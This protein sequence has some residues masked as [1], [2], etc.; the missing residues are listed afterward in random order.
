[1]K[2]HDAFLSD[3]RVAVFT[4]GAARIPFIYFCNFSNF[5]CF[6]WCSASSVCFCF[7]FSFERCTR[8]I[9][10][11]KKRAK[12]QTV[13]TFS[14]KSAKNRKKKEKRNLPHRRSAPRRPRTSS[15]SRPAWA[16]DPSTR[17][18][19]LV[20]GARRGWPGRTSRPRCRSSPARWRRTGRWS[21]TPGTMEWSVCKF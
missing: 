10:R 12:H 16:A 4:F 20:D 21:R 13:T 18:T 3:H 14:Q 6:F 15:W 7:A 17:R 8:Y 19:P 5:W 2:T 9:F 1:M 11:P